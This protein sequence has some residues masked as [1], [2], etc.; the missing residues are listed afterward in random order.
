MNI[1]TDTRIKQHIRKIPDFPKPGISFYDISTLLINTSAWQYTIDSL[2]KGI[3]GYYPDLLAGVESRG[4]LIASPL[5]MKLECGMVMVR[6]QGKLPGSTI[7]HG[8]NLEYGSNILEIQENIILPG[9]RVIV[10]DDLLATGGTINS[11]IQLL[12][13][14][15][16]EVVAAAFIVELPTLNGRS[17]LDVPLVTLVRY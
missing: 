1:N 14:V 9:Q 7:H 13:N 4:F 8:Y 2:A 12:R 6:K 16:A 11:A 17:K 10:V 15:H 3:L 5:A